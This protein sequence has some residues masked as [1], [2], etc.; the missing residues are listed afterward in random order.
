[1]DHLEM[2]IKI[3]SQTFIIMEN[4]HHKELAE[5]ETRDKSLERVVWIVYSN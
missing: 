5:S 4:R 3:L 1:M 2:S